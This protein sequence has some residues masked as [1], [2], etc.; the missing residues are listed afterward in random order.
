MKRKRTAVHMIDRLY[1]RT[2][3]IPVLLFF[4]VFF[5]IPV[6]G[7]LYIS[8]TN[9]DI[10]KIGYRFVGFRNYANILKNNTFRKATVNTLIFLVAIVVGRNVLAILLA[11]ALNRP[12]KTR[13]YLRTMFYLP[14]VL[15]YVVV[16]IMFN[17]L[18]QM[19][20]T[21]NQVLGFFGIICKKEWVAS[22]DTALMTVI[23]EDIW[24]WTGFHMIIYIAGL[25]AIPNELYEASR[26]DG[27]SSWKQFWR[28][29]LPLL[30][31]SLTINVTQSIIGGFRVFEQVL[32]L[33]G[34][35][36]GHEST[37]IGM[38]IYENF[39][40][41]FYGKASA[42]TMLLSAVVLIV[43]VFVRRYF[44]SKVVSY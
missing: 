24:K 11:M 18:F 9:W 29:T 21:V 3:L 39:C 35:G 4:I 22:A 7:G 30:I 17:A 14:A 38:L 10:T 23:F 42:M 31:P 2:F 36:P 43:T 19:D 37:V 34:G 25:T 20:G 26:I 44:S 1:P 5:I 12:L 13:A 41:G 28:I 15:S 40:N 32:T 8:F 33:T 27:A 6:I 16:G